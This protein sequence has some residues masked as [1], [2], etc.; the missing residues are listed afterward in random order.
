MDVLSSDEI[1]DLVNASDLAEKYNKEIDKES[2]YEILT[3]RMETAAV[4]NKSKT[5]KIYSKTTQRR[6]RDVRTSSEI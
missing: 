4:Q 2:A 3:K 5:R 6:A 1:D